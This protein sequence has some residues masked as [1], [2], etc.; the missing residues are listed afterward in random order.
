ML[1]NLEKFLKM[2]FKEKEKLQ[3]AYNQKYNFVYKFCEN[4]NIEYLKTMCSDINNKILLYIINEKLTENYK[5]EIIGILVYRI[6][7]CSSNKIRIYIPLIS[8]HKDMRAYGYGSIILE[9]F[10]AKY[11]KN[12]ILELVLLSLQ[13]SHDFYEKIGFQKSN[14]KYIY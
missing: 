11:H 8:I 7:L 14:V 4:I 13:S 2:K 1:I 5:N 12:K 6:I 3:K 9:E 10:I